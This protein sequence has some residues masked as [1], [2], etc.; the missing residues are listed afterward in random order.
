MNLFLFNTFMLKGEYMNSLKD[1]N[2][3]LKE[4]LNEQNKPSMVF[5]R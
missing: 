2:E 1:L 5:F 4:E 3:C